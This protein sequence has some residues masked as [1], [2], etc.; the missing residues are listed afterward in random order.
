VVS[1]GALEFYEI[2]EREKKIRHF[3]EKQAIA[4]F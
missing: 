2:L 3:Q 1:F 4:Y